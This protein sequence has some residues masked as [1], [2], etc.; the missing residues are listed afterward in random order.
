MSSQLA[1]AGNQTAV[2]AHPAC[3]FYVE[4]DGMTQAVFSEVSGLAIEMAVEE[5]EEGGNNGFVHRLPGRC[6]VGNLTLKRGMTKSNEFLKWVLEVAQG[7][8]VP[9][10]LSVILYDIEGKEF[11]RW[12]FSGAYPIKW[13]GP[14][15]KSDDTSTAIETLELAH[16]GLTVG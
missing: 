7:K 14:P 16:K 11:I 8:I 2:E 15:C 13:M 10:N 12:N 9:R 1:K 6:K 3:R 5:V 4:V